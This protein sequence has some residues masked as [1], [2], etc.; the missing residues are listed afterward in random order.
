MTLSLSYVGHVVEQVL[1][2]VFSPDRS[3][4]A[5]PHFFGK[6]RTIIRGSKRAKMGKNLL[7]SVRKHPY[8]YVI[9]LQYKPKFNWLW[10]L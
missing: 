7:Q 8:T 10:R 4:A 6:C 5:L 3:I 9:S 1:K 2:T